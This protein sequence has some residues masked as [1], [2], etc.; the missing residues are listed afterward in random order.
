DREDMRAVSRGGDP[1]DLRRRERE[2]ITHGGGRRAVVRVVVEAASE[3]GGALDHR[4]DVFALVDVVEKLGIARI[5]PRPASRMPHEWVLE[6]HRVDRV[7]PKLGIRPLS[8]TLLRRSAT[9]LMQA[10][11]QG[12][13][14]L[15]DRIVV[16]Q[17]GEGAVEERVDHA[18][19]ALRTL[20]RSISSPKLR[21]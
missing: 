15:G 21:T 17:L 3:R 11:Y 2:A 5:T 16:L 14:G 9:N 13:N 18:A 20:T 10:S 12:R 8:K 19:S 6:Q 7:P 1:I 4:A